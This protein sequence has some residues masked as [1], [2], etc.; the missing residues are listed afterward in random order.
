MKD[1]FVRYLERLSRL[2]LRQKCR[3]LEQEWFNHLKEPLPAC[4]LLQ[5]LDLTAFSGSK[6]T[7]RSEIVTTFVRTAPWPTSSPSNK[8]P[9]LSTRPAS[10]SRR[11]TTSSDAPSTSKKTSTCR[12][13][14]SKANLGSE[15][16]DDRLILTYDNMENKNIFSQTWLNKFFMTYYERTEVVKIKLASRCVPSLAISKP[17]FLP[18]A[19]EYNLVRLLLSYRAIIFLPDK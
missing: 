11:S 2:Q 17:G 3:F 9:T 15:K 14:L 7:P 4:N 13:F 12:E 19:H 10:T 5:A 18:Q 6:P 8:S 1:E 16:S